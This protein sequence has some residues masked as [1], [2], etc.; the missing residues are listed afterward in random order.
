MMKLL[1]VYRKE[2]VGEI[3]RF[4][5]VG[6]IATVIHY[7]VYLLLQQ[8]LLAG[9]A[10]TAGY[11]VSFAVNFILTSFFTFKTQATVRRGLGFML[12][13]FCNYLLQ[14]AL[15]YAVLAMGVSRT[16]APIPVYSIAIPLNF[17]MVRFV[18][19]HVER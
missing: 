5:V 18:F 15:L 14:M 2:A 4:V 6:V 8:V 13:H 1:E 12:A 7:A 10:Y 17:L 3:L 9:V 11:A 16:L 19:K